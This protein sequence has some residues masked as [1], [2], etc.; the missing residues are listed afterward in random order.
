MIMI[1]P[2][3]VADAAKSFYVAQND[4]S[5]RWSTLL[6]SL[7]GNAG[8]AGN[9]DPAHSFNAKYVPAMQAAWSALRASV[10]TLGGISLGLTQTANN[11]L[12]ADY[13]SSASKR[14]AL[15]PF[16]PQPVISDLFMPEPASALGPGETVWFLP[17]PLARFWPNAHT[18]KTQSVA[19]AWRSAATAVQNA[20]QSAQSALAALETGDDTAQAIST[21]WA[22]VYSPGNNTTVLAGACQICESLGSACARYANV[23]DAKRSEVETKLMGA[24]IAVGVTTIL[25]VAAS[26]ITLGGSDA[27]AGAADAAEIT[28]IVGDVGVETAATVDTEVGAAIAGDL[29]PTVDAAAANV[30]EVGIAEAETVDVEGGIEDSLDRALADD[31][32]ENTL[33]QQQL[34][35]AYDYANTEA[36]LS[37][38]ID[39]AKHGFADLVASAGGRSE[40]MRLI[41]DSLG[42][43]QDLPAAG[44]FA[45]TRIINGV[46][47]VIRGA[48]V[49]GI[50]K[51]GTAFIPGGLPGAAP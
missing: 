48:M 33:T 17:G 47:V 9:D 46:Q 14:R 43:G 16:P 31:T 36:K 34:D 44:P 18:D 25:G 38:I 3:D 51:I 5:E 19:A 7:D 41:I 39:P 13:H 6:A 20:T 37:H 50:P 21:F 23:I 49:D 10:L 30:P 22:Q 40:A 26:V 42:G 15:A 11:F 29:V 27:A 4:L 2:A 8:F 12:T 24:G 28:A 1:T 32:S 45:V 35:Q